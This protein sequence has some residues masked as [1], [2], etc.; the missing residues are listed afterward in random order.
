MVKRSLESQMLIRELKKQLPD[1]T[2]YLYT[3]IHR[4]SR[5]GEESFEFRSRF[6]STIYYQSYCCNMKLIRLEEL[7]T[8]L[9]E[10][11]IP[12]TVIEKK[13]YNEHIEKRFF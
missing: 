3:T 7:K 6:S 12:K 2:Y 4:W 10:N 5:P 1:N 9:K 11:W 13:W 8:E